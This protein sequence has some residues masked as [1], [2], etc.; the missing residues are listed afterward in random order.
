M[1]TFTAY[2]ETTDGRI[3]ETVALIGS[4]LIEQWEE[5]EDTDSPE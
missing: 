3:I 5:N 4:P 1:E 2:Q